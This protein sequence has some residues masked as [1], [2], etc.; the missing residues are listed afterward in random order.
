[1]EFDASLNPLAVSAADILRWI[2]EREPRSIGSW[3]SIGTEE[4]TRSFTA[5]QTAGW[6]V[7]RDIY[8]GL[9]ATWRQ[10]GTERDFAEMVTPIL[11][12]KGWLGLDD[13]ELG[14]R[15]RFIYDTN[16]RIARAVG[17]WDRI[18]KTKSAM[19]Y[20]RGV[21]V[22][23][24]RVRR[25]HRPF[26]GI[27]LP[28]DHPFWLSYFPPLYFRCRCSVIQMTRS[29]FARGGYVITSE[30]ELARRREAMRFDVWEHNPATVQHVIERETIERA[31]ERRLP[32]LPMIDM[33]AVRANAQ[34]IWQAIVLQL[35]ADGLGEFFR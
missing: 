19:P 17:R 22:R 25:G 11:R 24:N 33:N 31:N 32:G 21:T 6:D 35:I 10:G 20:L 1:M 27:V 18:Q 23:D 5:A 4:Y 28:V 3:R 16:L 9:E 26:D 34:V 30:A 7:V 14:H 8:E 12:Q 13:E 15:V 29:A 2:E